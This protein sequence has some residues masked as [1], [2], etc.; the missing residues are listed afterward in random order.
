VEWINSLLVAL[1]EPP[2]K[3]RVSLRVASALGS[4]CET[5]WGALQLEREPPMTRFIA[6]ELAKDHYFDL[7]AARHHLRYEPRV[8]MAE[9]TAKLIA[10]L[11][12]SSCRVRTRRRRDKE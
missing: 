2:I 4:V 11:K 12:S 9:G 3:K 8:S 5:I 6:A 1:G 7:S 10:S